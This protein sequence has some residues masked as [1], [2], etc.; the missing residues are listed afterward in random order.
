MDR[1]GA[2]DPALSFAPANVDFRRI[3]AEVDGPDPAPARASGGAGSRGSR[4]RMPV[5]CEDRQ[6][7]DWTRSRSS[8]GITP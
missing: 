1:G 7:K 6:T 8:I 3:D 4:E 2:D 5:N